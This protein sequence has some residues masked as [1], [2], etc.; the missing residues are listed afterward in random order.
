MK[1]SENTSSER[2]PPKMAASTSE[3]SAACTASHKQDY[4]PTNSLNNVSTNMDTNKASWYLAF[5]NR[6]QDQ[7]SSHWL[8]MTLA[9]NTSVKNMHNISITHLKNTTNVRAIGQANGT[10]GYYCIGTTTI[11]RFICPYQTM[12]RKLW[13]ISTQSRQTTIPMCTNPIWH[14]EIT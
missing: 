9:W 10:L 13:T 3:P 1:S 14:E 2:K 5:G 12:C 4:W 11:A 6:T 7:Y 8:L